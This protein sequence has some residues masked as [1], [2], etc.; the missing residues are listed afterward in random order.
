MLQRSGLEFILATSTPKAPEMLKMSVAELKLESVTGLCFEG[1]SHRAM[2]FKSKSDLVAHTN[3]DE[4]RSLHKD[5]Y[6]LTPPA[7]SL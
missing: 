6:S 1:E 7:P 5:Y 2:C 3:Q 4:L